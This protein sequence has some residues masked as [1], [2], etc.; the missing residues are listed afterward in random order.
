[1]PFERFLSG[2]LNTFGNQSEQILC[3]PRQTTLDTEL[4]L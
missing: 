3:Q 1:L 2:S 4:G